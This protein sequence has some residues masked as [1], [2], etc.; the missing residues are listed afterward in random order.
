VLNPLTGLLEAFRWSLV[1][2]GTPAWGAVAWAAGV[3]VVVFLLGAMAF[4][5]MERQFADV[6]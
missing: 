5:R 2:H 3:S 6:I 1:G 4:R